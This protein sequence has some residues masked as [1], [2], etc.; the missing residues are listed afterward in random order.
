MRSR[1]AK[2]QTGFQFRHNLS[3]YD[4]YNSKKFVYINLPFTE[5]RYVWRYTSFLRKPNTVFI[6]HPNGRTQGKWSIRMNFQ[7]RQC[8]L[9]NGFCDNCYYPM[10]I[11]LMTFFITQQSFII[12]TLRPWKQSSNT[13]FYSVL[14]SLT[15]RAS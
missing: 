2:M 1:P 14:R 4:E 15:L 13:L 5:V 12:Q 10:Q 7:C 11:L 8:P 3:K 6:L 9:I